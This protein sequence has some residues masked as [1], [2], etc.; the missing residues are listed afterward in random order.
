[1]AD[2][3]SA[4]RPYA[5]AVFELAQ[6]NKSF[7]AWGVALN[8]LAAISKD[9][10]FGDLIN[11]PRVTQNKVLELLVE[12]M[13]GELPEGGK[14]F[15]Q[16]ILKNR[17]TDALQDVAQQ[18]NA[19]VAKAQATINAQ[20]VSAKALS[21]EQRAAL[22]TALE[23]RLGLKVELEETVEASLV[24][25]AIVKAGDLVI[26]GSAKGRLEKLTTALMR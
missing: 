11:D 6:E 5:K 15:L 8:K 12:L 13:G 16:L 14:N 3:A 1:M 2:H 21:K 9:E 25:G 20:V 19:L 7:E 18:F 24:G 4:A 10:S 22:T 26:D 23:A 17:R